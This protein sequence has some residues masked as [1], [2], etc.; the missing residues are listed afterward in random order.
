MHPRLFCVGS[1]EHLELDPAVM[2]CGKCSGVPGADW[3]LVDEAY[4]A[5]NIRLM[6]GVVATHIAVHAEALSFE[7]IERIRP[8]QK[9]L[10]TE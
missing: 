4:G 2:L 5:D 10:V 7:R 8:S 9:Q 3:R 6:Q 1:L